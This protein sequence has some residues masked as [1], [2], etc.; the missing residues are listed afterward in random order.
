MTLGLE[1]ISVY[2]VYAGV[3]FFVYLL[4]GFFKGEV[5]VSVKISGR[6]EYSNLRETRAPG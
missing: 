6:A 1:P 2:Q 3:G 5:K 4:T